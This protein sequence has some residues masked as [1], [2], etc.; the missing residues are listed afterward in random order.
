MLNDNGGNPLLATTG[1]TQ[2]TSAGLSFAV[3][4]MK[5][6]K[7]AVFD[8][9]LSSL[10]L[11]SDPSSHAG[12]DTSAFEASTTA[13][14][15][16]IQ[17]LAGQTYVTIDVV[18]RN[19]NGASLLPQLEA[20]GLTD[21]SAFKGVAS[22]E[23][24]VAQLSQLQTLLAGGSGGQIGHASAS[25]FSVNA[26]LVDTQA[27]QAEHADQA[28]SDFGVDGT[29]VTVGILSDSFNTDTSASTHMAQD[30]A[31]G[32]LPAATTILQDSPGG[33]DEGRAMA[34]L[35]HDLAPGA[36]IDFATANGGEAAFANNIIALASAGAKVIV[37]DVIY[38]NELAYQEG[39]IAQAVDQVAA[40]GVAYFSAAGNNSNGSKAT[41]YEGAWV[42]GA[43]YHGGG[44]TT[45]LMSFAPGQD[46]IPVT[47][48]PN[49]TFVLQW[50][51][52]G[53][54]AGGPGATS[55]LDLFLT[56]QDGS[57]VYFNAE[58]NNIGGDPVETLSI[59]GAAGQT[60][61]LRVGL[62]QG[63][64]PPEIKL[65]AE[66]DGGTVSF[67]SPASN[68]NP[69]TF[70]G[71]AAA[72]GAMAVAAA[73]F[74]NTPAFGHTPPAVEGFSSIG[75]DTI[76]FDNSGNP[77]STPQ[78]RTP[79]F[80][81][82]DGGNTSFFGHDITGDADSFPNFFGTS[83]AAPDAAAVAALMLQARSGL[84]PAE[85]EALLQD[86]ALDMGK[87][88]FDTQTGSGLINAD[89]AVGYAQTLSI[90]S[91]QA[92]ITGTSLADTITATGAATIHG[93]DGNDTLIAASGSPASL[94]GEAGDDLLIGSSKND[95]L[96]GGTG[97]NTA[98][99]VNAPKGVTVSLA[100]T[101]AQNTIGAGSDTLVNIQN[102]TG[103]PFNDTLQGNGGDNVLDGGAGVNTV[104][105]SNATAG[106]TVDLSLAG[107][108]ATGGAGTDTLLNFQNLTGSAFNDTL[109][110]NSGDNVID[111]GAGIDTLTYA[112]AAAG[113]SVSLALTT[114]QVT[115][116]AGTDTIK[117]VENLTGSNFDDVLIGS[118]AANVLMGGAGNDILDGGL[119]NDTLD[120]GTG[121]NTASY[122][123][124]P[125]GVTVNLSLTGP[126]NTS[127][128][129][130][131]TLINIQNL[132]GSPFND[133]L[134][135]NSGDNVLDGG[136]GVNTVS[137]S[138]ATAGVTV[139]LSLTG[140]QATGGAGTDTLLNFQNLTGSAFND[141]LSG[142][143]GNN[144]LDGG[145]GI[146][147]LSYA[148]ATAG[149]T[150]NLTLN[151][152]QN[153]G[154]AGTDTVRNFENLTGS[155]FDD[156]LTGA[157]T[158]NTI[159]GGVG[160]DHIIGG[161][162]ADILWGG[163]GA[164]TFIY[165]ALSDSTVGTAGQDQIMDFSHAEGDRIDVSA[166]SPAFTLVSSFTKHPDQLIQIAQT[167]GFLVEGDTNGDG[168]ADFAIFVH[169]A[170]ALTAGD[171]VL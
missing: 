132:T 61:Y 151:T 164:D 153:T 141:T 102:L 52:P 147:T 29:G 80:T 122:A 81:A 73:S 135:G 161:G 98:S 4:Q 79:A 96:N 58:T 8:Q 6:G 17:T 120:G 78:S 30:I 31:S 154:G 74:L 7:L 138:T 156:V 108:Q 25:G 60:Y 12:I 5:S 75:P 32:D 53:A 33:T 162:G 21:A 11:Q 143:S 119:G 19:G 57:A 93:G 163:P 24:N 140:P 128:A 54:S 82:V 89:M 59:S 106:V 171:F 10:Y 37:D 169:A 101:G 63:A 41:G 149:V 55:D 83:A 112:G 170:F 144:T 26:G 95:T 157:S 111:S 23:I 152:A 113:V 165:K 109:A 20:A 133:T 110:G 64:A 77:L 159:M 99:Y 66:A 117:N 51:N 150:V 43:T 91:S 2:A 47:L 27:D 134:Q 127:A 92:V 36:A 38:Y 158:A 166:I 14:P 130:M 103:S 116:G 104:S 88:G 56:N 87:T 160:D 124:A 139:D 118:T 97:V 62:A 70:Y 126:Q 28:R 42:S 16:S 18:A 129:G 115:G 114:P 1:L 3:G 136:A 40:Q 148:S 84:T 107:P 121:V 49:E 15:N 72:Q 145:A 46:Y 39:P 125:N 71:H 13:L 167:G 45:T 68:T 65:M 67:T 76:L 85:I 105:Y 35:V 94:Y 146:D 100:L 44:E 22:G 48:A 155:G 69:G 86:S 34:Q 137:Y 168:K 142:N 123:D 131:D 9:E 50:A 90:T